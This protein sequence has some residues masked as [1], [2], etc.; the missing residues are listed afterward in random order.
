LWILYFLYILESVTGISLLFIVSVVLLINHLYYLEDVKVK[1]IGLGGIIAIA[2]ISIAYFTFSFKKIHQLPE[3]NWNE[4]AKFTENGE[5]YFHDSTSLIT[6]NEH[7]VWS[8]IAEEELSQAWMKRSDIHYSDAD[9]KG[10]PVRET[11]IR[12]LTSKGLT[13]D[14]KGLSE[15][16]DD[17]IKAVERSVCNVRFL[18]SNS[19]SN[20]VYQIVWEISS[21]FKGAIPN[22][23]SLTMRFEFWRAAVNIIKENPIFGVGVGDVNNAMVE[24]YDIMNSPLDAWWKLRAHN[25]YLSIAVAS[26]IIGLLF[27]LIV[28]IYPFFVN[29]RSHRYLYIVFFIIST[30]SMMT[31]DLLETQAG[32]TF[33]IFFWTVLLF[34]YRFRRNIRYSLKS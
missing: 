11:L 13:K 26:G 4:V 16:S 32:V 10:N 7:Y 28:L 34:G 31:E 23:H 25:Q 9:L 24:R 14:A 20:R 19:L 18:T 29:I 17:E 2:V 27:F 15:L 5:P 30:V 12:F 22:G 1:I 33:F 8:Y 21:Y 3:I 6:E